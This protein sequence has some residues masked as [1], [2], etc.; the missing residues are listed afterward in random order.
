MHYS[1]NCYVA[2]KGFTSE[3]SDHSTQA[4]HARHVATM[5]FV[6]LLSTKVLNGSGKLSWLQRRAFNG[7]HTTEPF[8]LPAHS[9]SDCCS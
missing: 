4:I 1:I 7:V 8:V 9:Y 3:V 5:R 6:T 2:I